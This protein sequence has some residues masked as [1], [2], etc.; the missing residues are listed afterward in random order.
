[1][2]DTGKG[3]LKFSEAEKLLPQEE[4]L[5]S[6]PAQKKF[7][8]G[9]PRETILNESR[10][11]LVPDGINLLVENGHTVFVQEDAGYKANFSNE[12][13]AAA[14]AIV[15]DNNQVIYKSDIIIKMA[16]PTLEELDLLNK[17]QV[18][19]SSVYIPQQNREYFEKLLQKRTLAIAYEFIQ[20]RS[21]TFP[22]VHS[23]SEIVGN[24]SVLIAAE[25]LSHPVMGRGIMLGGF[26]GIKPA[27]VVIIGAGTV[28]EYATRTALGMGASVKIFDNSIYKLRAIQN[29][30]GTR[31][32]TTVLQP[33]ELETALINA[34]VVIAAKHSH[35]GTPSCY[36]S[37]EMVKKMK[38]GAVIVD[39]SIDQGG[40]FE[41]SRP[42]T[43][44]NPVYI[45]HDIIHYCVPNIASRVPHTASWSLSNFLTPLILNFGNMGGLTNYLKRDEAFSKGVY[46]FNGTLT[47]NYIGEKFGIRYHDFRLLLAALG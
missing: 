41:T 39:V 25:Y 2:N 10:V 16:P 11:S 7:T 5:E 9:I 26:P 4:M 1:M 46:T 22:V 37:E 24:T 23:M 40:C 19:F 21:G 34:N 8:I 47:N 18:L 35:T 20:D 14:G 12:D 38:P 33:K 29:K 6:V 45:E 36:I 31:L 30:L 44:E 32:Y 27:E 13:F 42:T 15:V 3:F 28:A 43:H 17:N